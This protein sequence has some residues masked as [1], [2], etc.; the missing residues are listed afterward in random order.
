M[1]KLPTK[2]LVAMVACAATIA[3]FSSAGEAQQINKRA[4][5]DPGDQSKINR[6]MPK[7]RVLANKNKKGITS[8]GSKLTRQ[9]GNVG[10]GNVQTKKGQRA[11]REVITVVRGDVMQVCK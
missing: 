5:A 7:S 1:K 8:S 3:L 10:V 11:P 4:W 2:S 6:V 9:C